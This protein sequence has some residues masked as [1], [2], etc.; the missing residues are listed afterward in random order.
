MSESNC[1]TEKRTQKTTDIFEG[2]RNCAAACDGDLLNA[3]NICSDAYPALRT[4]P[5]RRVPSLHYTLTSPASVGATDRLIYADSKNFYYGDNCYSDESTIRKHFVKLGDTVAIFPQ[6]TCF[7]S[8]KKYYYYDTFNMVEFENNGTINESETLVAISESEPS[9]ALPGDRYYNT[10]SGRLYTY[11]DG[12][13]GNAVEPDNTVIYSVDVCEFGRLDALFKWGLGSS[14]GVKVKTVGADSDTGTDCIKFQFYRLGNAVNINLSAFKVGDKVTVTGVILTDSNEMMD[15]EALAAGTVIQEIGDTYFTVKNMSDGGIINS[16]VSSNTTRV[17][18]QRIVPSLDCFA[19]VGDRI[20]GAKGNMIYACAPCDPNT[21][22]AGNTADTALMLDSLIQEDIIGCADF[23]G[24]PI[25]FTENAIIEVLSVYNGYKLSVTPAPGLSKNNPESIAFVSG[26]LYYV[27]DSGVMCYG[28]ASP[29]RINFKPGELLSSMIGGTDGVKYYLSGSSGT[30]IYDTRNKCWYKESGTF[31]SFARY[32]SGLAGISEENGVG[33][34]YLLGGVETD[35]DS[36]QELG[37]RTIEFA[38]FYEGTTS[39]KTYSRLI[40]R[41][42]ADEECEAEI[43]VSYDG[44]DFKKA[45]KITG[46]GK[47]HVYDIPLIPVKA[48]FMQIRI[49]SEGGEFTLISLTREFV[50]HENYN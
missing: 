11:T 34:V 16:W 22:G 24:V 2:I 42:Q 37:T 40:M 8:Y 45:T 50:L 19:A 18:M 38:P 1:F 29:K 17:T 3:E 30:Y 31:T 21:W 12:V 27:S 43:Y 48:D 33:H 9:D 25:F 6:K 28:G 49:V 15:I 36:I 41:A 44:G 13:W 23:G 7:R 35:E 47:T 5:A 26:S 32:G 10:S 20:W 4:S 39:K 46:C 14:G